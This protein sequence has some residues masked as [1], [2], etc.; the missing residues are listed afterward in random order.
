M[1]GERYLYLVTLG[2]CLWSDSDPYSYVQL[3]ETEEEAERVRADFEAKGPAG[4]TYRV[5]QYPESF[6]VGLE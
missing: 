6:F 5:E 1:E 4:R 3:C 2:T